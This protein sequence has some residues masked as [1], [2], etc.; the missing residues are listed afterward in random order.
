MAFSRQRELIQ[1]QEAI[2]K[3]QLRRIRQQK[4]NRLQQQVNPLHISGPEDNFEN[5]INF[6]NVDDDK[7][8]EGPLESDLK[9]GTIFVSVPSYRDPE[10][11]KTVADIFEKA[12]FPGR[13]FVGVCQQNEPD[14]IDCTKS[15]TAQRFLPNIR[16]MRLHASEARGPVYARA[17]IEQHLFKNE[18]Y[19]CNVD[20]HTL[21]IPGWDVEAITQLAQCPSDK[22][23]LTCYPPDYDIHTRQLPVE[24]PPV[25]LKF[26]DFHPRLG[27]SQ[28]DPARF[29]HVPPIPQPSLLWG[30]GFS[31]TLGTVVTEVPFDVNLQYV[32][33]GEEITMAVRLYTNG[34]DTFAPRRNIVYHYTPRKTASGEPRPTFWEQFY[35][36]DGRCKVS[37]EVREE[38]KKMEIQGNQRMAT[39]L[40]GQPISAPYGL[41]SVRTLAQFEDFAGLHFADRTHRRHAKLGLTYQATDEEKY[42][43]YGMETFS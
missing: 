41:G 34:Y 32:F 9:H 36:K 27:L 18:D 1:T 29:R 25:F 8:D 20:S 31:F 13:I 39:L 5:P 35:K 6:P 12:T 40:S 28:Q 21:F 38:R 11:P 42:Y 24:Q 2:W 19:Y 15:A 7:D 3:Q 16:I 17:L 10:C 14:D 37:S 33:L 43:K 4:R 26:R 22:P 30:G 23:V